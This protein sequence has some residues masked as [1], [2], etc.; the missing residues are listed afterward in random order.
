[1]RKQEAESVKDLSETTQ[2]V[3]G[4]PVVGIQGRWSHG[5]HCTHFA[6]GGHQVMDN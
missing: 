5:Q 1:V 6:R 4:R 3:D 2:L